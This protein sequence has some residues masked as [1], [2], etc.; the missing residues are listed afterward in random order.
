RWHPIARA[1]RGLYHS[2]ERCMKEVPESE[3]NVSS[4]DRIFHVRAHGSTVRIELVGGV[5]TFVAMAYIIVVNPAILAFAGIPPGPSTVATILTAVFGTLLMGLYANRPIAVAPYMGENAFIAF[6][7]ALAGIGWELRLGTV[8]VSGVAFALLSILRLRSCLAN[9]VSQSMKHSFA[10]GIGLFLMLIGLFETGIVA[11]PPTP[12]VPLQIGDWHDRR[13]Q[14]ALGGF[15]VIMILMHWRVPGAILLG[16]VL[17]GV[18][19]ATLGLG[20]APHAVVAPPWAEE[21]NVS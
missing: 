19:G 17:T 2:K 5:T 13:V 9:A 12:S 18:V 15:V 4:L 8:F 21:Y 1:P 16:M 7:L 14:L 3:R 10:V 11:R 6:S 20:E